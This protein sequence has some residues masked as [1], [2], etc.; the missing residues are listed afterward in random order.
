MKTRSPSFQSPF[1]FVQHLAQLVEL[2]A[3]RPA[4]FERVHH[5]I[6]GRSGK[7]ALQNVACQFALRLPGRLAGFI[8][9]R[10]L[11]LVAA[12]RSLGGHDLK[13]LE[14]SGVSDFF[15]L[16][17]I[18]MYFADGGRSTLPKNAENLQFAG[19]RFRC[20]GSHSHTLVRSISYCQR[21]TSYFWTEQ[22]GLLEP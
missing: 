9:M 2:V 13:Q 10:A 21:K 5:E 6:A 17:Q 4:S 1:V 12:Y 8:N 18:F 20:S 22:P 15:A 16:A 14:H 3:R 11:L 19:G 7:D